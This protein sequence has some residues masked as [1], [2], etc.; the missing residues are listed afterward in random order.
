MAKAG[1][2][3]MDDTTRFM[4]L[5]FPQVCMLIWDE[6]SNDSVIP[7]QAGT[8]RNRQGRWIPACAGMTKK[9]LITV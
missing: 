7:A 4:A 9:G 2:R 3:W 8:Q 5:I 1:I 6:S